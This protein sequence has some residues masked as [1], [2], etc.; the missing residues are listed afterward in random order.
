MQE[1]KLNGI[2]SHVSFEEPFAASLNTAIHSSAR[3]AESLP[4]K[5]AGPLDNQPALRR[6]SNGGYRSFSNLH[7][8]AAA[9][10]PRRMARRMAVDSGHMSPPLAAR[11]MAV[12]AYFRTRDKFVGAAREARRKMDRSQMSQMYGG[13][14]DVACPFGSEAGHDTWI[15]HPSRSWRRPC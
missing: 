1:M 13:W 3:D 4:G 10:R 7:N 2:E 14:G 12:A 5:N 8:V 15:L 11:K 6:L 9:R